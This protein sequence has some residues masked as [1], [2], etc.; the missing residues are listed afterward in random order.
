MRLEQM[1]LVKT[2]GPYG[3]FMELSEVS[4]G[5]FMVWRSS[6]TDGEYAVVYHKDGEQPR[7]IHWLFKG[8]EEWKKG[9]R[10]HVY[11]TPKCKLEIW[12]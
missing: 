4:P 5:M 2:S 3:R 6:L 8:G 12:T 10:A 9:G 7:V 11:A 1:Y